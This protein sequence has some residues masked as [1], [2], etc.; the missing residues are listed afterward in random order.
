MLARSDEEMAFTPD[1]VKWAV[2]LAVCEHKSR[3]KRRHRKTV[4]IIDEM[5]ALLRHPDPR[6][7]SPFD[8][9]ALQRRTARADALTDIERIAPLVRSIT[10]HLAE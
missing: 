8:P 6:P 1:D 3:L 5:M 9:D 7:K 4:T 10:E 2:L